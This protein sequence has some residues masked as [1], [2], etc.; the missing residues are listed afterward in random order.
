ME[1]SQIPIQILVS[2]GLLICAV[3]AAVMFDLIK[4]KNEQLREMMVELR[5]RN[6]EGARREELLMK[7]PAMAIAPAPAPAAVAAVPQPIMAQ[8]EK[9]DRP[10]AIPHNKDSRKA[11]RQRTH[12]LSSDAQAAIERG[13]QMAGNPKHVERTR[14][15]RNVPAAAPAEAAEKTGIAVAP[16]VRLRIV[17]ANSRVEQVSSAPENVTPVERRAP[18]RNIKLETM[19]VQGANGAQSTEVVQVQVESTGKKNW[20]ALLS[21]K[22]RT[23]SGLLD[24][25]LAATSSPEPTPAAVPSGYHDGMVLSNLLKSQQPVSGLVVS[26]GVSGEVTPQVCELVR[27]LLGPTDFGCQAGLDEF[28]LIYPS[29][30]GASAQRK[31]SEIAQQLWNFQLRNMGEFSILFS[32]GGVEARSES[33]ENAISNANERMQETRRGRS[34]LVTMSSRQPEVKFTLPKA[35]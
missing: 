12:V 6:D 30:R 17:P 29:E 28:L 10:N 18:Y 33:V 27:S 20:G 24:A 16:P 22:A 15:K 23:N 19:L 7:L 34:N 4:G 26:I 21:K 14:A 5:V 2:L 25:V 32:W 9:V 11:H 13:M 8:A 35:V 31:L 1:V 3:I